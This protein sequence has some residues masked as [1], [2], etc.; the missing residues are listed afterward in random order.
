MLINT[1]YRSI[2]DDYRAFYI[3]YPEF[4]VE[5]N[6]EYTAINELIRQYPTKESCCRDRSNQYNRLSDESRKAP[7]SDVI[8]GSGSRQ[9]WSDFG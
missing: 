7:G 5:A 8:L 4:F 6:D 3:D 1:V 2:T 9:K